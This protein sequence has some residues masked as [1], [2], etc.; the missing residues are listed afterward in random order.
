MKSPIRWENVMKRPSSDLLL[1]LAVSALLMSGPASAATVTGPVTCVEAGQ[2]DPS[3]AWVVCTPADDPD[4][5]FIPLPIPH[6]SLRFEIISEGVVEISDKQ[7]SKPTIKFDYIEEEFFVAGT[8]EMF[9]SATP[10]SA[11]GMWNVQKVSGSAAPY[12]MRILVKRP[13]DPN[14]FNGTV[15]LEFGH[16]GYGGGAFGFVFMRDEIFDGGYAHVLVSPLSAAPADTLADFIPYDSTRYASIE[17]P[18][19]LVDYGYDMFTQAAKEIRNP[20]SMSVDPMGGLKV[21]R[22][23]A[24][25]HSYGAQFLTTYINAVQSLESAIDGFLPTDLSGALPLNFS[26]LVFAPFPIFIRPDLVDAKV[27][28]LNAEWSLMDNAVPDMNNVPEQPFFGFEWGTLQRQPDSDSYRGYEYSGG[29]HVNRDFLSRHGYLG[30]N[31][32]A[33]VLQFLAY[34]NCLTEGNDGIASNQVHNAVL[35]QLKEWIKTGNP[36]PASA[37]MPVVEVAP[38]FVDFE[39]DAVGNALGGIRPVAI[40]VPIARY[41]GRWQADPS[42]SPLPLF[43]G[44]CNQAGVKVPLDQAKL[45]ELYRNHDDYVSKVVRSAKDLKSTGFL[46]PYDE[47]KI[48][49]AAAQSDIGK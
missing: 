18:G 46:R 16:P 20:S 42:L 37:Q 19:Q 32:F 39:R 26:E 49:N 1:A 35:Y 23:I 40:D 27:T 30:Y 28:R 14:K 45:D 41:D 7:L 36:A 44:S 4:E 34:G 43:D 22:I 13:A 25:G 33:D 6:N 21:E 9:T 38:G 8:A 5:G 15:V 29:A 2:E 11:D 3:K 24:T 10:L 12:K 48:K 31:S 47:K 17:L